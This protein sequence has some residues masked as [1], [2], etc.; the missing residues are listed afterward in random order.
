MATVI[1]ILK[2]H[3]LKINLYQ[4]LNLELKLEDLLILMILLKFVIK[5]GKIINVDFIVFQIK[6]VIQY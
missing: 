1:G 2:N 5:L 3:Y 4:L 6:K